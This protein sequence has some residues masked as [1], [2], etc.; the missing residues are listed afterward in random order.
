MSDG[1][2]FTKGVEPIRRWKDTT[3]GADYRIINSGGK[4]LLQINTGTETV[5]PVWVTINVLSG[6]V[7]QQYALLVG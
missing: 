5:L 3:T 2:E 6:C 4:L 1:G 7:D